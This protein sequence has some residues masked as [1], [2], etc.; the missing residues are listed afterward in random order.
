MIDVTFTNVA[1]KF[2]LDSLYVSENEYNLNL[3]MLF[4]FYK[5]H[6]L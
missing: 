4:L 5:Y 3:S 6:I 1:D 2:N